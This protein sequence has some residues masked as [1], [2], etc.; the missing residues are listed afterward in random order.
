MIILVTM[1]LGVASIATKNKLVSRYFTKESV[2]KTLKNRFFY[3]LYSDKGL[4]VFAKNY[5]NEF[6]TET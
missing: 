6:N 2:E 3:D 4:Q 5:I 1:W